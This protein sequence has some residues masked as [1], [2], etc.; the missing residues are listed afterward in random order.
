MRVADMLRFMNMEEVVQDNSKAR[1]PRSGKLIHTLTGDHWTVV[2][3]L[4]GAIEVTAEP[5]E[6]STRAE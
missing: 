6:Y 3:P 2:R 1:S 4:M 5:T